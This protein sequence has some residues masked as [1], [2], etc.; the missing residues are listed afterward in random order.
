M[1][2]QFELRALDAVASCLVRKLTVPRIYFEADW[3]LAK[4]PVDVLAIDR[5]GVGEAHLVEIRRGAMAALDAARALIADATAPFRWIAFAKGTEDEPT[6]RAIADQ[7]GL[8]VPGRR[9]RVGIIEIVEADTDL[10]ASIRLR[11]ERFSGPVFDVAT[12]FSGTHKADIQFG[13]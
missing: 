2:D 7:T 9:G 3:P 6:S 1:R 12:A 4:A 11:A 5:D 13:G 10:V 8:F